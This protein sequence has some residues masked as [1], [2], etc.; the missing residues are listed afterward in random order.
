MNHE[1]I[2][3]SRWKRGDVIDSPDE[4]MQQL[5][6]DFKAGDQ[7]AFRRVFD[8]LADQLTRYLMKVYYAIPYTDIED[9]VA[10]K[11]SVLYARRGEM[12]SLDHVISWMFLC[13]ARAATD[14]LRK[15]KKIRICQINYLDS[16]D[17]TEDLRLVTFA[18]TAEQKRNQEIA[19]ALVKDGIQRLTPQRKK[20]IE[21]LY[22][23]HKTPQDVS[24]IMGL[25]HQT[26]L[27]HKTKALELIRKWI[28]TKYEEAV[29]G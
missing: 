14:W 18:D 13:S 23:S 12:N 19:L 5:F 27:N 1:N 24:R 16:D 4:D 29:Y 21:L 26:V 6:I 8:R 2:G 28:K 17:N 7:R 25:T 3:D 22:F 15:H 9:I 20:V 10:E 11:F